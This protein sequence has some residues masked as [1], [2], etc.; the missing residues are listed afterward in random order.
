MNEKEVIE[1]AKVLLKAYIDMFNNDDN[2]AE[3]LDQCTTFYDDCECDSH[4]LKEDMEVLL[5]DI[6]CLEEK[7]PIDIEQIKNQAIDEFSKALIDE[8]EDYKTKA[9]VTGI[10]DNP[11]E[12]G[13]CSGMN[14][15]MKI[16]NK[17]TE[18]YKHTGLER[19]NEY[20]YDRE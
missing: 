14:S 17:M 15:A 8:L 13:A 2:Y 5:D 9:Y 12:F 11:Y 7:S 6:K 16:V 19:E 4:C 20:E 3:T 10:T 1:R 18:E